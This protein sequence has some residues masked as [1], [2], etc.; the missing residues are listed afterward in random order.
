MSRHAQ[1]SEWAHAHG[2]RPRRYWRKR[3]GTRPALEHQAQAEQQ[4]GLDFNDSPAAGRSG[5][6][7]K[8]RDAEVP[9]AGRGRR[10]ASIAASSAN[11]H[12]AT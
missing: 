12:C 3:R 9:H 10:A 2:E 8:A 4:L 7:E 6:G 11:T 1:L 5:T